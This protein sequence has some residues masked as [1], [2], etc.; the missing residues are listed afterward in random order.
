MALPLTEPRPP[1]V[2]PVRE[3]WPGVLYFAVVFGTGF[4]LG[5]IRMLWLVPRVGART[6]ELLEAPL[7]LVAIVFLARWVVRRCRVP[8]T[9]AARLRTGLV[10]LAL[11]VVAELSLAFALQGLTPLAYLASRDPVSGP[12]YLASVLFF[13]IAPVV[14]ARR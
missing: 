8:A 12:V 9:L 2:T 4:V 13:A 3:P 7:M 10:A 11:L 1:G 14:V 5:P 6:A